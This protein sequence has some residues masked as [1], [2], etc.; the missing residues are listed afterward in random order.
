VFAQAVLPLC[1]LPSSSTIRATALERTHA[2]AT[3]HLH[4]S[5]QPLKIP[6]LSTPRAHAKQRNTVVKKICIEP[7]VSRLASNYCI[8]SSGNNT[9]SP[10]Q[11]FDLF[12][13]V[14]LRKLRWLPL[15]R[16][17]SHPQRLLPFF[18]LAS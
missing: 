7:F 11:L 1:S 4:P 9:P 18:C 14:P 12:L 3:D 10:V 17:S 5:D 8:K 15:L 2:A 6:S 13:L 16:L